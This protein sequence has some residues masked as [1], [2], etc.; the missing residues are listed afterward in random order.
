MRFKVDENLPAE[1]AE[2]LQR[3]G[4]EA[5][6]VVEQAHRGAADTTIASIC[7]QEQRT[8]ITLDLDFADLRVYPPEDYFGLIVLRLKQQDR[9][10]VLDV[11]KHLIPLLPS[12]PVEGHLWIVS[13]TEVRIRG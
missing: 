4:F 10:H 5:H 6:T 12:E 9:S 2:L 8:L 7:Q 3:A 1:V 11:V 13:E